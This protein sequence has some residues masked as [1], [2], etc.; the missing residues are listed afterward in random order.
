MFRAETVSDGSAVGFFVYELDDKTKLASRAYTEEERG[1]SSTYRELLAFH[2]AWTDV[3]VLEKFRNK[4]VSHFTDSKAMVYILT[5]GSRNVLLQPMVVEATLA[6]RNFNVVVEPV[7]VS[8]DDGIIQY[9][10]MGS[11]DFHG[12]DIGVDSETFATIES[13]FGSFDIDCFASSSNAKCPRFFS[14]LDVPGSG[15][16]KS[17][18]AG[19]A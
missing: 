14:K 5:G 15:G 11:R 19:A 13:E 18:P 16:V 2:A 4:R 12:D 8:R 3:T 7:W 10:D 6:L 1:G 17:F 9:A